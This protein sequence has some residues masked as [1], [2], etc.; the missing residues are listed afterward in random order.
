MKV[1]NFNGPTQASV[2]LFSFFS[3]T[4]LRKIVD[5]CRIRTQIVGVE[6]KHTDHHYHGPSIT[7]VSI[8]KQRNTALK[9]VKAYDVT[10]NIQPFWFL[11]TKRMLK[12]D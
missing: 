1:T 5:F 4:I 6:G 3:T 12:F 11:S 8:V 9:M 2:C 10:C 7:N